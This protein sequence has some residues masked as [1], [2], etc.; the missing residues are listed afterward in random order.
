VNPVFEIRTGVP[1]RYSQGMKKAHSALTLTEQALARRR[2]AIIS[3][4]VGILLAAL[5]LFIGYQSH[6][7]SVI[8]DGLEAAGDVLCSA[9]VYLGLWLAGKPADKEHPYGHGRYEALAGLAVGGV[10]LLAGAAI[11][12]HGITGTNTQSHLPTY[13]LYPLFLAVVLKVFLAWLKFR[14]GRQ[15]S[16]T[17]LQAD[18]W[19]DITDL[20]STA[21]ALLAVGA[22]LVDPHRFGNA[23]HIG[24]VLIGLIVT[25]LAIQVMHRTID[26]LLDTMPEPAKL[27]EIRKQALHV[28]GALGIEK[29]FARRTGLCY[30]VDLH[31][32]VD[33]ALTVRESHDIA[34][35]VRIEVK[36]NLP[37]V[38]DV[39]VHVEPSPGMVAVSNAPAAFQ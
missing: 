9:I 28:N 6:S 23:D 22:T 39:L 19:H 16:S 18:A 5:K 1:A 25:G 20:L 2:I 14:T 17:S 34:T 37:W 30:H 31:L 26:N 7:T 33:P 21:I 38:A 36:E 29:C 4:S 11:F 8:S 13:A 3:V 32:E 10:L 27:A 12:W 24:G 35:R 15:I